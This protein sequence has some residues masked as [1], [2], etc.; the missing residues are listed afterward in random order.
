MRYLIAILMAVLLAGCDK[1]ADRTIYI[2]PMQGVPSGLVSMTMATCCGSMKPAI[3]GG[4]K[5]WAE[6]YI[7]QSDLVGRIVMTNKF[8]HRVIAEGDDWV[9]TSG[10]AN[11]STD[12]KI[13]KSELRY[14]IKYVIRNEKK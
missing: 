13:P 6:K 1:P 4:E 12:G 14:I 2:G 8:T 5:A 7:N 11:W 3:Q 10:D 9:I